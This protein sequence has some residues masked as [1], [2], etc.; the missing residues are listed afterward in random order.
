MVNN[1]LNN[2]Q[3]LELFPTKPLL[4]TPDDK[5]FEL[6]SAIQQNQNGHLHALRLLDKLEKSEFSI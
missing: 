4:Q 2:I 5:V 6:V 1:E 3:P